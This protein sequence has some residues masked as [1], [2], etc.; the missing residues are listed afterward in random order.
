[1]LRNLPEFS[2]REI[3]LMALVGSHAYGLA[4]A[5]SD[6]DYRGFY[7]AGAREVLGI[8]RPAESISSRKPD[9]CCYELG[10]F[11]QLALAGNPN[12][13]EIL[14]AQPVIDS[15]AAARL[16]ATR[17]AFLS[18][19]V[20]TTYLKYASSQVHRAVEGG[21]L[22]R[23]PKAIRHVFRLTEQVEGILRE[24]DLTLRVADPDRIRSYE[25]M[26]DDTLTREFARTRERLEALASDLPIEPER[27]AI[28]D[29][30]CAVRA[31]MLSASA[32]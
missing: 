10:R 22:S 3:G 21:P 2:G 24:G 17:H 14:W 23:R 5:G 6:R 12:V 13:L 20:R 8:D 15:P 29:V 11:A 16:R 4:H 19:R 7:M 26:D 31:Q 25:T 1:M 9:A 27:E 30:I 18:Q 32:R 28:I